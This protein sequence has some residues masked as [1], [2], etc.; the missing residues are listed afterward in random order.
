MMGVGW[1]KLLQERTQCPIFVIT[2]IKLQIP[3]GREI[4]GQAERL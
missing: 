4:F 1:I 2:V 3:H